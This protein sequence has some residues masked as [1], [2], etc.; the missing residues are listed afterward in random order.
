MLVRVAPCRSTH[1]D[2]APVPPQ[3]PSGNRDVV[4]FLSVPVAPFF[5][6]I[7]TRLALYQ[8]QSFSAVSGS[9]GGLNFAHGPAGAYIRAKPRPTNPSSPL[10]SLTRRWFSSLAALW[11]TGL[12]EKNRQ[13]W[14]DYARNTPLVGPL[15]EKRNRTGRAMFLRGN[16][17]RAIAGLGRLK[18]APTVFGLP[19]FTPVS[20]DF[21]RQDEQAI[22]VKFDDTDDWAR[23]VGSAMLVFAS[24]PQN[25]SVTFYRRSFRFAG[26]IP[27]SPLTPP[28]SPFEIDL[29]FP[30]AGGQNVFWRVAVTLADARY[31]NDQRLRTVVA[32]FG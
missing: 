2:D 32:E 3:S 18:P 14:R 11:T 7:D 23:E 4:A 13:D 22:Q 12:T 20:T 28:R 10:Q 29:P 8:S 9:V 24:R 21:I 26:L 1:G 31:S 30:V 19:G 15:G 17:P 16:V 5:Q 27:G 6:R 25:E